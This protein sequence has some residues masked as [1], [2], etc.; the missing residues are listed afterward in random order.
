MGKAK[1]Y[2][3]PGCGREIEVYRNPTPA[4]D[5]I[6]EMGEGGIVLIKRK[7]PPPGWALPGGFV[8][9][10]ETLEEAARREAWEETSLI[11][12]DLRQ[13]HTY[14]HPERDPRFH[15]IATVFIARGTGTPK[16]RDDA[17]E[18]GIFSPPDLPE[19]MAFDHREILNDYLR[20][21]GR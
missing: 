15:T 21:R 16:A 2:L 9:L 1:K 12:T 4:V 7:N 18:I 17:Q 13:M 20:L 8:D 14:S 3:C 10:G 11:V 5:L 19:I 6:I